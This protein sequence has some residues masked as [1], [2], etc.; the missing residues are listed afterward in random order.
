MPE[1][2]T[3]E[4]KEE[5]IMVKGLSVRSEEVNEVMGDVPHWLTRWG[6]ACML[7]ILLGFGLGAYMFRVPEYLDVSFVVKGGKEPAANIAAVDGKLTSL[8]ADSSLVL[9]NKEIARIQTDWGDSIIFAP[10]SGIFR[11]NLLCHKGLHITKGDTIGWTIPRRAAETFILLSIPESSAT[12]VHKGQTVHLMKADGKDFVK[13]K[14]RRISPIPVAGQLMAEVEL[15]ESNPQLPLSLQ[16]RGL[17]K[18]LVNNMRLIDKIVVT[19]RR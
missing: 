2:E 6:M 12:K 8:I 15:S 11:R 19:E 4:E 14:V 18:V 9:P 13:G 7:I 16:S 3:M 17:A 1:N 10:T 5:K